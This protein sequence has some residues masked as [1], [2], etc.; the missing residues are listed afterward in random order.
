MSEGMAERKKRRFWIL[1]PLT[2]SPPHPFPLSPPLP[3]F[4]I[5]RPSHF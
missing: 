4:L 2:P 1:L 3:F 5:K